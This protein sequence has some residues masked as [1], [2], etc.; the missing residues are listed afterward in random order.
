[1][2]LIVSV[3]KKEEEVL[4]AKVFKTMQIHWKRKKMIRYI[5]D[6][7]KF[8]FDDFSESDEKQI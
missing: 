7:L 4:F 1:M 3:L 8:P 5:I 2:I 6:G